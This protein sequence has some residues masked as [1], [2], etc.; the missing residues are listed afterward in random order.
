L[1]IS[2]SKNRYCLLGQ[3]VFLGLCLLAFPPPAPAR[4]KEKLTKPLLIA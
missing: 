4:E 3:Q 1:S 2:G